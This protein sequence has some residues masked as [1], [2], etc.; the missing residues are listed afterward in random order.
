MYEHHSPSRL[1]SCLVGTIPHELLS[2][3]VSWRSG[4]SDGRRELV[5]LGWELGV[6]D[7]P[8]CRWIAVVTFFEV[9]SASIPSSAG[10]VLFR[11]TA[12]PQSAGDC[13]KEGLA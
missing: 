13:P 10:Y 7:P 1:A 5:D 6:D 12:H 9:F 4:L 3:A 2:M 11:C 8:A